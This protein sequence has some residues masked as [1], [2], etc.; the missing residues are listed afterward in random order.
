ME[1]GRL[2]WMSSFHI[3]KQNFI[4]WF[5]FK[6]LKLSMIFLFDWLIVPLL[7]NVKC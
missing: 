7:E 2:F 5:D 1:S 4:L 6:K 3:Q